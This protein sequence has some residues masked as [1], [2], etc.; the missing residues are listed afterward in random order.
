MLFRSGMLV[1]EITPVL[2]RLQEAFWIYEDQYDGE[3]DRGWYRFEEMFPQVK[4]NGYSRREGISILLRRYAFR[5]VWFNGNMAKS[6]YRLPEKEIRSAADGLVEKGIF[7]READGYLLAEDQKLL[8]RRRE[9]PFRSVFA[10]HRNDILVKSN[11]YWL[12]ERYRRDGLDILQYLFIDGEFHGAV[13]G[14]FKNGPYLL[15]DVVVD[16]GYAGRQE[17]IVDAIYQV[18]SREA[19]PL[20][21][22]LGREL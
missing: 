3:W 8:S 2:H 18:N 12:K 19:S 6:F 16:D 14:H 22:F 9:R 21:Q 20:R 1:K 7:V 17:E 5:M 11:E 13:Q 10:L 4:L 15:E